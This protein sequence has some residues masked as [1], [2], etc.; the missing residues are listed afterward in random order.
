MVNE[1]GME[2]IYLKTET[3]MKDAGKIIKRMV[4]ENSIFIMVLS[5]MGIGS[6]IRLK[7]MVLIRIFLMVISIKAIGLRIYRAEK[8]QRS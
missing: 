8:G 2:S 7:A 6:K 4:K 5:M 3:N 1:M